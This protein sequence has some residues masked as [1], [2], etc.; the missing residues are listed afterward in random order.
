MRRANDWTAKRFSDYGLSARLEPWEFGVTWERGPASFRIAAPFERNL[1]G[2]SW[3]WTAGTG[4]KTLR[5]PGGPDR[6]LYAESIA[7]YAPQVRGAGC[8]CGRPP[9][10]GIRTVRP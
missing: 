3:A 1:V 2:H 6:C 8:S 4:G 9:P 7:V 5:W 10:S